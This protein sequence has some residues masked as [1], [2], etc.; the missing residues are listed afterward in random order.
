MNTY[1]KIQSVYKRCQSNNSKTFLTR[2]NG[3]DSD[4]YSCPEF[5]YLKDNVWVFTEKLDG[6]NIRI[7][8][9]PK[10][11]RTVA[12]FPAKIL[13]KGK[14]DRAV[15]YPP[16]LENLEQTFLPKI[17][18]FVNQ[19]KNPVC[20]YGEGVGP[21]IQKNGQRYCS[22]QNPAQHFV[23]F[24]IRIG[25]ADERGWWLK[26][27]DVEEI[28]KLL[29]IEIAPIIGEGT[30]DDLVKLCQ[31]GFNSEWSSDVVGQFTAEGIVARPKVDLMARNDSRII[32]KLKYKDFLHE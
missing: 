24:D 30:L 10:E 21:K 32:T 19:F 28:A 15:F 1:H 14:T 2:E 23:L 3:Y 8:F 20:L 25:S 18:L 22:E 12:L 17:D 9:L 7:I 13:F 6:T 31:D 29:D 26:R 5:E 4:Q 11:S 27:E 16:L